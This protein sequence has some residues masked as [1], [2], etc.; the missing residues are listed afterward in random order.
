MK[1]SKHTAKRA[2]PLPSGEKSPAASGLRQRKRQQ[3]R[4][5]LTRAAMSLFLERGFEATTV[6][7]IVEGAGVSKPALYRL[8]ESKKHLYLSLL[9][10][11]RDELAAAALAEVTVEGNPRVW[12]PAMVDAWFVY[13]E[14]HPFTSRMFRDT[15][16]DPDIQALRAELQR[17]QR[18]AD[19]ALLREFAPDLP[20]SELEPLGEVIRSSLY[21]LAL[22][23]AEHPDTARAALVSAMVRVVSGIV[24]TAGQPRDHRPSTCREGPSR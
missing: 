8:F 9:E 1:A 5:R 3:T 2:K 21:G 22:W 14:S 24:L 17:R 15:T 11:H 10:R 7:D 6:D 13:V 4:E 18:A 20:D 23:W 19:V 16:A 12:L